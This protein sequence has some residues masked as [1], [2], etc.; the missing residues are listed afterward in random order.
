[1]NGK[2]ERPVECKCGSEDVR[3][4]NGICSVVLTPNQAPHSTFNFKK[5]VPMLS[6]VRAFIFF[7]APKSEIASPKIYVNVTQMQEP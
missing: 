4:W 2:S 5:G 3:W 7:A 6:I 1:M